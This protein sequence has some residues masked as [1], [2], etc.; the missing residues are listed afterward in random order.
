MVADSTSVPTEDGLPASPFP[1]DEEHPPGSWDE[2]DDWGEEKGESN[3]GANDE[4][5]TLDV[6]DDLDK[7][8]PPN[9]HVVR[10]GTLSTCVTHRRTQSEAEHAHVGYRVAHG[11]YHAAG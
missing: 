7:L 1:V 8:A 11:H 2:E 9:S 6:N 10:T 5:A 3:I 4:L